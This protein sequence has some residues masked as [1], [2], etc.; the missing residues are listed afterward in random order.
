MTI[1]SLDKPSNFIF[2]GSA[3]E[4][5]YA[6]ERIII[7]RWCGYIDWASF[8]IIYCKNSFCLFTCP[9]VPFCSTFVCVF[10]KLLFNNNYNNIMNMKMNMNKMANFSFG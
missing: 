9:F 3:S 7:I 8:L 5:S 6:C 10:I 2:Q 4:V 1:Y